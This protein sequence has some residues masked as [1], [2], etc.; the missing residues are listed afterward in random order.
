MVF[1]TNLKPKSHHL[2]RLALALLLGTTVA[3]GP[4]G[5]TRVDVKYAPTSKLELKA[6]SGELVSTPIR[7]GEVVDARDGKLNQIGV[8]IE[9]DEQ[10]P[11]VANAS[12]I[13]AAVKEGLTRNFKEAG[14][15]LSDSAEVEV[16]FKIKR[17]WVDE[18]NTY[19]G[20]VRLQVEVYK[21]GALTGQ[22]LVG[23]TSSRWG[24]SLEASNYVEVFSDALIEAS[25]NLFNMPEFAD[26]V[27][28]NS[29]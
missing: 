17:V 28:G 4:Q 19:K 27:S 9:N 21:A 11:A 6:I 15:T 29:P 12:A 2:S 20:E 10:V 25:V 23:G 13:V 1:K 7:I 26:A 18:G 24:G 8:N 3:C 22:M 5:P 14:L 16:R